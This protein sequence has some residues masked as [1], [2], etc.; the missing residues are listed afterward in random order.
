LRWLRPV[1]L[2]LGVLHAM[3]T[4]MHAIVSNRACGS[5]VAWLAAASRRPR[6]APTVGDQT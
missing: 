6:R 5:A 1:G 2:L 3:T 4:M